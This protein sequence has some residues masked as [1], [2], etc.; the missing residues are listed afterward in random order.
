M[1]YSSKAT[2]TLL[3]QEQTYK[4]VELKRCHSDSSK[5]KHK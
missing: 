1:T 3:I 2:L 5:Q 4:W